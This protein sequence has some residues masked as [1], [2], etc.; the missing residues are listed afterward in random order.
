MKR[1]V[2]IVTNYY[3]PG[4]KS[5]GPLASISNLI[6]TL[7]NKFDF[8]VLTLNKDIGDKSP[9]K[10]IEILKPYKNVNSTHY[11]FDSI[12]SLKTNKKLLNLI[13]KYDV[14][15]LNSFFNFQFSIF[16]MMLSK[17]SI[18]DSS[19]IIIAPRGELMDGA[20][21]F[22]KFKKNIF[23][24]IS[25]LLN[26]YSKNIWHVSDLVELES[27][28]KLFPIDESKIHLI[29]NLVN[30]KKPINNYSVSTENKDFIKIC[31]VS[32]ISKKKNLDFVIDVLNNVNRS[33]ILDIYGNIEDE[34]YFNYCKTLI[35]TSGQIFFRGTIPFGNSIQ[36]IAGYDLF[37][38]PTYGENFGHVIVESLLAGT[39]V[40]IS[41]N[42]PWSNSFL[43]GL[44]SYFSIENKFNFI[45][46]IN[47]FDRLNF[48][49]KEEIR[50]SIE[51]KLGIDEAIKKY[52]NLLNI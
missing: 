25:K 27:V 2:L 35:K 18:I 47:N 21:K 50:K 32:R 23:L 22:K 30:I 52:I 51:I 12:F 19:K 28:K 20:L 31:F 10:D 1:K 7:N 17:L 16:F 41:K 8:S 4:T 40:L 44:G 38:L 42:T 9:Y 46:F 3:F 45:E 43:N 29:P 49:T 39:P 26:L 11:Y 34:E 48:L 37:F 14:I 5:G 13:S 33:Y 15:Y 6:S 36:V 24:F